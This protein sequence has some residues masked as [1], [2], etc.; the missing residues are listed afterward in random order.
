M[1]N[2]NDIDELVE[3]LPH[4]LNFSIATKYYYS[5]AG[6]TRLL[7]GTYSNVL[8]IEA[9]TAEK[10]CHL[11]KDTGLVPNQSNQRML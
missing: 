10:T 8:N 11:S 1:K 3:L 5:H 4:L 2:L 7:T 6:K 9:T